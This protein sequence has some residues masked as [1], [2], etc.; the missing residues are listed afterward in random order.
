MPG[1][2][3]TYLAETALALDGLDRVAIEGC[4]LEL[5]ACRERGGRVFV[6]GNGGSA[7]NASHLVNDLRKIAHIEAYAPTDNVAEFTARTNDDGWET[8][9]TEWLRVSRLSTDDL[10][11]V[12][13][14]GGGYMA[15]SVNVTNAL[16]YAA[17]CNVPIIGIVGPNGGYT[18]KVATV[19]V[20][21]PVLVTERVTP[22]AE[23]VQSVLGHLF[24]SHPLLRCMPSH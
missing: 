9:F 20:R 5:A 17:N 14:V 1:F 13:S 15:L 2:A 21:V 18:A 16:G 8:T 4:V 3:E 10:V 22:H 12:L 7:A 24:V 19:C 6:L 11:C 23:E